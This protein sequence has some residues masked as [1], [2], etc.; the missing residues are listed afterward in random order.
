MEY[1][2]FYFKLNST[3]PLEIARDGV[4]EILFAPWLIAVAWKDFI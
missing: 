4:R 1:S 3:Y 2:V